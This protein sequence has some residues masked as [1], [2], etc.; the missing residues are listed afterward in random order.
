[1]NII[2]ITYRSI[3]VVIIG[4]LK[5]YVNW[6]LPRTRIRWGGVGG[7]N[8]VSREPP[9]LGHPI[10]WTTPSP[11]QNRL[12]ISILLEV[13]IH[14]PGQELNYHPLNLTLVITD[15]FACSLT[16]SLILIYRATGLPPELFVHAAPVKFGEFLVYRWVVCV[17][18]LHHEIKDFF[19]YMSPRPEEER[20]RKEVVNRI[21]TVIQELWPEAQVSLSARSSAM[22][23]SLHTWPLGHDPW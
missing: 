8:W 2:I 4:I 22:C 14:T 21:E 12:K 18:R 17:C 5:V 19:D 10:S 6:P 15:R 3:W 23:L 1:M 16:P 13:N 20:M 7:H 9:P 11:G